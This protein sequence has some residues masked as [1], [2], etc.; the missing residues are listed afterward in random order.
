MIL[1]A[2]FRHS[3]KISLALLAVATSAL[4]LG[5]SGC[6]KLKARDLLNKGVAAYRDGKFDD[7]V[8]DFKQSKDLDPTLMNARLYLATAYATEYIPGAPSDEN[9]RVGQQA[10]TEFQDVLS[11][12][13]KNLSAL[14]GIGSIL[15][16]MAG[17]PFDPDK[18]NESKKYHLKHIELSP[19]DPEPYYWVG[20]INWTLAYRGN[21]E[22]R[23]AYNLQSPK[24]QIKEAD[25]L[26]DKVRE[27][28]TQQYGQLVDEGLMMLQKATELRPDYADAVAYQSLLLRQKADMSDNATRASLE[29]QADDL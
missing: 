16:N 25:P 20:V 18:Y 11:V 22:A 27:Q 2:H 9:V 5:A 7:A 12:D 28:L 26:P 14:D 1:F 24:N 19:S 6:A 23:Q 15:Y 21:A 17:T 10:V 13:S 8:E 3:N 4:A 29:K